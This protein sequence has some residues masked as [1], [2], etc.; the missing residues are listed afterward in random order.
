MGSNSNDDDEKV[1]DAEVFIR[2]LNLTDE[3]RSILAKVMAVIAMEYA[4]ST[5]TNVLNAV[6]GESAND[7][8][9]KATIAAIVQQYGNAGGEDQLADAIYNIMKGD[10]DDGDR[11][12][13]GEV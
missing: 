11:D 10:T 7:E 2:E 6:F 1:I 4:Q 13:T 5:L 9:H 8:Q 3:E 12:R